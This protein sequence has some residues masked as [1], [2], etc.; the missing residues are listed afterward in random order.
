IEP[1]DET[2]VD[3][4]RP[5]EGLIGQCAADGCMTERTAPPGYLRVVSGVGA[6]D[7]AYLLLVPIRFENDVTAVIEFGSFQPF[8][9][10]A[11]QFLAEL[12]GGSLGILLQSI[13]SYVRVQHLLSESQSYV[14]ELQS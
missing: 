3:S 5:G 14:E 6:A 9:P 13:S 1:K 10:L 4:F 2:W 11:K 12:A 8:R 7:A